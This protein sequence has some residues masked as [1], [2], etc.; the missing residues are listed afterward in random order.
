MKVGSPRRMELYQLKGD[1]VK[2]TMLQ[3]D[4]EKVES[5]RRMGLYQLQGDGKKQ[6]REVVWKDLVMREG[7]WKDLEMDLYQLQGDRRMDLYQLQGDGKKQTRDVV[8]ED[9]EMRK[10]VWKD[11]EMDLETLVIAWE[12]VWEDPLRAPQSLL[13]IW[14]DMGFLLRMMPRS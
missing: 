5:V 2:Q 11:L 9:L 10:A 3:G 4:G 13:S 6:T 7:V 14:L 12:V 8:W 1:G